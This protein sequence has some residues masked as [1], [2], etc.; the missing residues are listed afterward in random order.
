MSYSED[1]QYSLAGR[2]L[3]RLLP[4]VAPPYPINMYYIPSSLAS[5]VP[6]QGCEGVL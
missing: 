4:G 6:I 2:L 1:Y 5:P 3:D